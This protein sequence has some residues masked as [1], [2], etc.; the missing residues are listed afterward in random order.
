MIR[1]IVLV[2]AASVAL[3]AC[4]PQRVERVKP[5]ADLLTC[6]PEPEAPA[7]PPVPWGTDAARA[8]QA[9]RDRV[10]L[11]FILKLVEAGADCRSRVDGVREWSE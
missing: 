10:T 5:P 9:D 1:A 2:G 4:A 3:T 7:L 11:A 6:A 8:V